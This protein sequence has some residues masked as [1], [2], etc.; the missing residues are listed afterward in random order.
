[1]LKIIQDCLTSAKIGK[2]EVVR[3]ASQRMFELTMKT[4]EADDK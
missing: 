2:A 4:M 3:V 1:M